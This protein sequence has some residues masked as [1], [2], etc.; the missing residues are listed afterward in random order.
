M[1]AFKTMLFA[2]VLAFVPQSASAEVRLSVRYS[3]ATDL[4]SLMDNT[5]GWLDGFVIPAYRDEWVKRFGW[6][7][8][9]QLWADRYR[10]YRRRTY[11]LNKQNNDPLTSTDGIFA[12]KF[13]LSGGDPLA[14]HFLAHA[15]VKTA[16]AGLGSVASAQD[17]KMLRG[18]YRHFA[19][20]W[21]I[22]L[23]ESSALRSKAAKLQSRFDSAEIG[24]FIQ[25]L[26]RF[27]GVQV[28][29]EFRVFFTRRPPGRETSAE[30][31][32]GS[33]ILLHSPT[34]GEGPDDYW[35]TIVMHELVHFV[36]ARQSDDQKRAL[37]ARFLKRCPMPRGVSRLWLLEEPLAVAWGQAAYSAKVLK[38]PLA[39]EDN[40][41][42]D[43]WVNI[44]SR[45]IAPSVIA[46]YAKD[47]TITGRIVEE[48]ADR[49]ED[50]KAIASQVRP[51]A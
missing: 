30:P 1:A 6:S 32:A 26:N 14:R 50:L 42:A 45:A 28:D 7:A 33:N 46:G 29:G 41:Y 44:V 43:P 4:F 24:D 39:P 9:D 16:L 25:R 23:G 34:K 47:E 8:T 10:E 21:R 22:L 35:D 12:S 18:F 3:E 38:S 40:W 37:T 31:I 15:D 20:K 13:E 2:L 5:S 36:S 17:A 19:P 11:P 49:C 27:Y 51:R 48:A